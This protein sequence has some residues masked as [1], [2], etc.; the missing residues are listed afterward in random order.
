MDF[1]P[2]VTILLVISYKQA[3]SGNDFNEM[4]STNSQIKYKL[5]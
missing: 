3:Y 5:C 4:D 1:K 2:Q